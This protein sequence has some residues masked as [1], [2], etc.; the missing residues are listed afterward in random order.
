M[1][2][3]TT[4]S[5]VITGPETVAPG[6]SAQFNVTANRSDG[7][8]VDAT[9]QTIWSTNSFI[10]TIAPTGVAT[11]HNL[12]ETTITATFG[13]ARSTRVVLVLPEGTFRVVGRV[14]E[15]GLPTT[16][17]LPSA[18]IEVTSGL[19]TGRFTLSDFNG[20]Y[21]LYGVG[22]DTELK[23]SRAAYRDQDQRVFIR[24]HQTIDFG[25]KTDTPIPMVE[26]SYTLTITAAASCQDA[27]P[28]T[29]RR[30]SHAATVTHHDGRL[31]RVVLSGG[32]TLIG[33]IN[34][35]GRIEPGGITF[36]VFSDY[37]Y[38]YYGGEIIERVGTNRL[39]TGGSVT[40]QASSDGISGTLNG[41]IR[42][43]PDGATS[44]ARCEATDHQFELRR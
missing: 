12:G 24:E 19:S 4:T 16:I 10:M 2:G 33:R 43:A 26:G 6:A 30:R 18:R 15:V 3:P 23:A 40:A 36:K 37:Y 28:E 25:L 1:P 42:L 5:L 9:N 11:G 20:Y 39:F 21:R 17:P 34:F 27:L 22:G 35:G 32:T 29:A 44:I 13:S 41:W 31:L 8:S 7:T 38:Y 14:N